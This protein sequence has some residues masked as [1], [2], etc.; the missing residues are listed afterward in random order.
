MIPEARSKMCFTTFHSIFPIWYFS[1]NWLVYITGASLLTCAVLY[2]T[3]LFHFPLCQHA[4]WLLV[5]QLCVP[6]AVCA[7]HRAPNFSGHPPCNISLMYL[8]STNELKFLKGLCEYQRV[9]EELPLPLLVTNMF[10]VWSYGRVVL[11]L[12]GRSFLLEIWYWLPT[13]KREIRNSQTVPTILQIWP[14]QL[15]SWHS[16]L[17]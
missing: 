10:S 3:L 15:Y 17:P 1:G 14:L 6:P 2:L 7:Q 13:N 9:L 5:L 16:S 12:D 8:L 11:I 4:D